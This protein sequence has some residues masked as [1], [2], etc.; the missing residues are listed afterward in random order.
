MCR[1]C[2][3]RGDMSYRLWLYSEE[4]L[5]DLPMATSLLAYSPS[6]REEEAREAH[7]PVSAADFQLHHNRLG[8]ENPSN[9][10]ETLTS[11]EA[12][13]LFSFFIVT[14]FQDVQ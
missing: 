11:H 9:A 12:Y 3:T 4:M 10:D 5:R 7:L 2:H 13:M 14:A 1:E 6:H 8:L